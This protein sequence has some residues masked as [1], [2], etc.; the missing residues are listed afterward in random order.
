[1]LI[2][3]SGLL[4]TLDSIS[5]SKV[6]NIESLNLFL[7]IVQYKNQLWKGKTQTEFWILLKI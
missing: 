1:M 7:D 3:I 6:S 5:E 4:I 2:H